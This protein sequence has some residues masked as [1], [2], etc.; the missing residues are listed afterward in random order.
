MCQKAHLNALR[1]DPA[2]ALDR[3]IPR[4]IVHHK[5]L[6]RVGLPSQVSA[7][8]LKDQGKPRFLVERRNDDRKV[9]F[10]LCHQDAVKRMWKP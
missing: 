3:T 5:N 9:R 1:V 2:C 7:H 4:T 6:G 8:V 10:G